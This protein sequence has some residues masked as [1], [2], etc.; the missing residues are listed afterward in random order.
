ML[1]H[2]RQLLSA[3]APKD[4]MGRCPVQ[5]RHQHRYGRGANMSVD[6]EAIRQLAQLIW[7]TEGKPEG[8]EVRHWDMATR[9]AE[10]AAMAPV[11]TSHPH[12]I[13]ALFPTPDH[14]FHKH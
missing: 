12:T 13:S 1:T 7:E 8:Q 4:E 14:D 5:G 6:E 11:R 9:L 10:S 2:D 3:A